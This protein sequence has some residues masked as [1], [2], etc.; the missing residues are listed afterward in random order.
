MAHQ[1]ALPARHDCLATATQAAGDSHQESP[2][3]E[4][5]MAPFAVGSEDCVATGPPGTLRRRA[6][7]GCSRPGSTGLSVAERIP[8]EHTTAVCT[9]TSHTRPL[10]LETELRFYHGHLRVPKCAREPGT[11]GPQERAPFARNCDDSPP[12]LGSGRCCCGVR[13]EPSA[14]APS[15]AVGST[16]DRHDTPHLVAGPQGRPFPAQGFISRGPQTLTPPP[17]EGDS[18]LRSQPGSSKPLPSASIQKLQ[19]PSQPPSQPHR[20]EVT[21]HVLWCLSPSGH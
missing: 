4:M 3:L 12:G 9:E 20:P 2:P 1:A 21:E 19:T 7:A 18:M 8:A 15:I 10:R 16:G 5:S 13:A 14:R 11:E 6:L 17:G